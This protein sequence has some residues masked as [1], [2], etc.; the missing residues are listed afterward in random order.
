MGSLSLSSTPPTQTAPPPLSSSPPLTVHDPTTGT[1][2][3]H[4]NLNHHHQRQTPL[5]PQQQQ[6]QEAL[7]RGA[8][9]AAFVAALGGLLFG[10]DLGVVSGALLQLAADFGLSTPQREAVVSILLAGALVGAACSGVIVDRLG[11]RDAMIANTALFALGAI[12]LT[13][14]RDIA[15]LYA[16]RA[17][18]GF[19]VSLSAVAEVIYITE[20]APPSHRGLLVSLNEVGIAVGILLA[21][22][23]AWL[24][25][26]TQGGWR[27]MF[28]AGTLPAL[29]QAVAA[30]RLPRSPRWLL[31]RG[32]L[33]EARA[34]LMKVRGLD[35]HACDQELRKIRS[36]VTGAPAAAA[37]KTKRLPTLSASRIE[38]L[39]GVGGVGGGGGGGGGG[40]K[41]K[42]GEDKGP[43]SATSA[44]P[45]AEAAA[46]GASVPVSVGSGLGQGLASS[47]EQEGQ[48]LAPLSSSRVENGLCS[49]LRDPVLRRCLLIGCGVVLFQQLT[50]QPSV[51]YYS[52]TLLRQAG[53]ATDA[54]ATGANVALGLAKALATG[55]AVL[56][57]DGIG[58]RKLLLIGNAVMALS[59]LLLA[60]AV[61][62]GTASG[63]G[64]LAEGAGSAGAGEGGGGGGGGEE[65]ISSV[66]PSPWLALS[67]LTL[68]VTAYAFSYGPVSWLLLGEL[69]PD[70]LRGRAVAMATLI[71][72]GSNFA[73]S[74]TFL[75]LTETIGLSNTFILYAVVA[76]LALVFVAV[77]V[78]ETR[79][80]RLEEIQSLVGG[81]GG[82]GVT[83][84]TKVRQALA[85]ILP[86]KW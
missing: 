86:C 24:F 46:V 28:A 31:L 30:L 74:A 43:M 32:R 52:A 60:A 75:S 63:E 23:T 59:L 17:L 78:P 55:V 41:G 81:G 53:W 79:G 27:I 49:L 16:G 76:A 21:Y 2:Y 12:T 39:T 18:I 14:A 51:V 3:P 19:A 9:L 6:H 85:E 34:A 66:Q 70:A 38:S 77:Y 26:G 1:Q 13:T 65:E 8:L 72:W 50:G 4:Q 35:P 45:E 10:Y 73:V 20:I 84:F 62:S 83:G 37:T 68:Y 56:R 69:F 54:D 25:A 82:G 80:R 61:T 67:A 57:V 15:S 44:A 7:P 48:F 71:N 33:S 58:R 64:R 11:R 42:E 5:P 22:V 36:T 40:G 29:V 47:T